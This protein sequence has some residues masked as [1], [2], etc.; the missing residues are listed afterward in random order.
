[1]ER[2]R[3][4]KSQEEELTMP[5]VIH[6]VPIVDELMK[7]LEGIPVKDLMCGGGND[8]LVGIVNTLYQLIGTVAGAL[9]VA[10]YRGYD[11]GFD[12]AKKKRTRKP[13]Q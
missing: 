13:I 10:Y 6:K 4:E 5:S 11:I 7:S 2:A 9:E 1:M 8:G 3:F 12:D